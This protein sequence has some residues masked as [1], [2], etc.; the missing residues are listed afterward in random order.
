[1]RFDIVDTD[2]LP[3]C[4]AKFAEPNTN[5]C[6]IEGFDIDGAMV[7]LFAYPKQDGVVPSFPSAYIPMLK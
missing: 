3:I 6:Y 4:T 2:L 5:R 7:F 1:M